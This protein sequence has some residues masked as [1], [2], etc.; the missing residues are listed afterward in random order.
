MQRGH[1]REKPGKV[2]EF[3][4][5]VTRLDRENAKR[6]GLCGLLSHVV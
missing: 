6:L 4:L 5:K 1:P 3:E 2:G